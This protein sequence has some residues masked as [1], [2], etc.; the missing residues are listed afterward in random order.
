MASL[1][2]GTLIVFGLSVVLVDS[3]ETVRVRTLPESFFENAPSSPPTRADCIV[4][5]RQQEVIHTERNWWLLALNPFVVV[6]DAAPSE[7]PETERGYTGFTP[8]RYISIGVRTARAGA[9]PNEIREECYVDDVGSPAET[10]NPSEI[11]GP[12]WPFGLAFLVVAGVGATLIAR[13]R[14]RTPIYRLPNGTRIA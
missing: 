8:M 2:F 5:T 6:A 3:E 13:A 14:L 10:Q 4:V 7:L 9:D 11:A 1:V 12:V